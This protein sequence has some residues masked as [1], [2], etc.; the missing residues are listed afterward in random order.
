MSVP[1]WQVIIPIAALVVLGYTIYRNVIPYPTEGAARWFPIVAG[2]WLLL[3]IIVVVAAPGLAR[4]IGANLTSAEGFVPDE[5]RGAET[6]V[7]RPGTG[8]RG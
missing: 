4:R 6:S 1:A 2:V 5:P 8:V 3:A 7:H